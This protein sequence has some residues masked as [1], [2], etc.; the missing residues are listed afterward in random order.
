MGNTQIKQGDEN[1][2]N[3]GE[4]IIVE[5]PM[6]KVLMHNDAYTTKIFIINVLMAYFNKDEVQATELM[7]QVHRSGFGICGIYT[8]DVAQTKIKAVKAYSRER[9]FALQMSLEAE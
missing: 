2:A 1:L 4:D 3:Q 5:P 8:F 7:W 6:Y 9:G